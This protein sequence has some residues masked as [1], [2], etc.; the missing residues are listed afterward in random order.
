[1]YSCN[2]ALHH[3]ALSQIPYKAEWKFYAAVEHVLAARQSIVLA[4][5]FL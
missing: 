1:M 5:T 2:T 3:R 4:W